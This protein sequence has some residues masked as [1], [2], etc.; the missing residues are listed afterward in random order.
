M[1]KA[2]RF[3]FET[4]QETL[5][6]RR[7]I[8]KIL[9]ESETHIVFADYFTGRLV[10]FIKNKATGELRVDANDFAKSYGYENIDALLSTDA[11]LELISKWKKQN[12]DGAFLGELGSGAML[13]EIDYQQ[14]DD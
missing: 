5:K 10:K 11:G 2:E 3:I 8:M 14:L 12:P 1:D 9:S 13:E 4:K 7:D 6:R